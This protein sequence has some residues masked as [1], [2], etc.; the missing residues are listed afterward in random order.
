MFEQEWRDAAYVPRWGIARVIRRQSLAEHQY[1]VAVYADQIA[2]AIGW[3]MERRVYVFQYALRHDMPETVTGDGP[4]PAK[5]AL[6]IDSPDAES[7]LR[8]MMVWRYG[9]EDAHKMKPWNDDIRRIVK[10]A[11]LIDE[12]MYIYEEMSLGNMTVKGPA[13]L[14]NTVKR[15]REAIDLLPATPE[16]KAKVRAA[17]EHN[18]TTYETSKVFGG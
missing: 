4:G 6:T 13:V 5:R 12:A 17:L 14:G 18:L 7:K 2:D 10:V 16:G 3:P 8:A 1:F 15:L 11:D 9:E